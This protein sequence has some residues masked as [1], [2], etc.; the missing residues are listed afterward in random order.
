MEA[1]QDS[2]SLFHED[3]LKHTLHQEPKDQKRK[4]VGNRLFTF[5]K[6]VPEL[7]HEIKDEDSLKKLKFYE[8]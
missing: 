6:G 3:S 7:R 4:Y 1:S 2:L 8:E 5:M